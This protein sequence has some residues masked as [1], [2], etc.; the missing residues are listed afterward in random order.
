MSSNNPPA[1]RLFVGSLPYNFTE[2]QLLGL[3][4]AEGKVVSVQIPLDKFHHSRGMGFVEFENLDDAIRAKE[5]YH[6]FPIGD[7]TIIVDFAQLDPLSTPEGQARQKRFHNF[8]PGHTSD[9]QPSFQ[10]KKP[11]YHQTESGDTFKPHY[12]K[13]FKK[14]YTGGYKTNRAR[15]S[16]Y[17][18]RRFGSRVGAKLAAK[19]RAKTK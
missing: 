16:V 11:R 4:I 10:P 19:Q 5:K 8:S 12:Q 6:N 3:F 1:K 17:N 14:P 15:P 13:G 18:S 7:R 9:S 2:G